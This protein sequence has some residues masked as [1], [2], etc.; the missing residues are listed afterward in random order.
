MS[1][2]HFTPK[3]IQPTEEQLAIQLARKRHIVIEANAGAAKTTTLALRLAQAL[4]R[5]ADA[6]RVLAL[7]YTDTAVQALKDALTRIGLDAA[8]RR[9]LHVMTFEAFCTERMLFIEGSR[10][11]V[12][13]QPE[14]LRPHVLQAIERVLSNA[15]ERHPD[16]FAIQGD[17]SAS[18]E[19]LLAAFVQLKGSMLLHSEAAQ[20]PLT[21]NLAQA[22]DQDYTTLKVFRAYERIRRGGHPDHHAFR[23]EHDA[24]YDL[25]SLLLDEDAFLGDLSDQDMGGQGH[26]LDLG[27]HLVVVDEMHDT[28]R[29]MFTV[30]RELMAR[31]QAAFVGVGDR[32]Q[33][34]HAVAG[35]DARFMGE[36]F[37]REV[38]VATRFPLSTT[39]RFGH[40]LAQAVSRLAHNK[41]YATAPG[42]DSPLEGI[43]V[44]GPADRNWHLTRLITERVG[45]D[46][47]APASAIAILLRHPHQSVEIENHLLD[48]GIDY[49]TTGFDT[50]LTRPEVLFVRGL[51]ACAHGCFDGIERTE[52][53]MA[54]LRALLTFSG[55]FVDTGEADPDLPVDIAERAKAEAEAFKAICAQPQLAESFLN[56]QVLRN[57]HPASVRLIERA[58]EVLKHPDP[59]VVMDDFVAAL[60]PRELASR[61]LV[62]QQDIVQV[63]AN[64]ASLIASAGGFDN[65]ASFFRAMNEREIRRMAMQPQRCVLISSIEAAKGLEFE[66]V[67]L[68]GLNRG[69]FAV[70]GDTVDNRNLLYVAMTRAR[71]RLTVLYDN[72]RPSAYLKTLGLL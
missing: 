42:M 41:P 53:R 50:Y 70:G 43:P 24:T 16:E 19:G 47:K 48:K 61:L 60:Q 40:T 54:V 2:P 58:L 66:H 62:R 56:N 34:I 65:T 20:H 3:G 33:V 32:D 55:S 15:D 30:L 6:D 22:L 44:V 67:I 11:P 51:Y 57:G 8:T 49:R 72:S 12:H 4:A 69:E 52:T 9:R 23:G 14:A 64:I 38:A 5:G 36:A 25:A 27:L 28:N 13:A 63:E 21:P 1:D 46:A 10:I 26:P 31:N 59:L 18:V 7:T 29:A 68:P 45:L 17:G 39:W 37:D 71:R 35:A